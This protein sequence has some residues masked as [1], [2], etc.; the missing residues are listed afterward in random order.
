[1]LAGSKRNFSQATTVVDDVH[2]STGGRLGIVT[3]GV[4]LVL[5]TA[6]ACGAGT[7]Q[8]DCSNAQADGYGGCIPNGHAPPRVEAAAM[9]HF[10]QNAE[11]IDRV[12]CFNQRYF[13]Q[14]AKHV[15]VWGCYRVADGRL[16]DEIVC[17][18][19]TGTR[20]LT[21]PALEAVSAGQL[22]CV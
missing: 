16:T 19:A 13:R 1:V 22:H 10:Q 12:A 21:G 7:S 4:A 14:G 8:Y 11:P 9:R 5:L 17:I 15:R 3:L 20:P 18:P 2:R 6:S